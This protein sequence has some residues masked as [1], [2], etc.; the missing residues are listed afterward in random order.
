M[1]GLATGDK[2]SFETLYRHRY[3]PVF[4]FIK[5]FVVDQQA[6][7]DITTDT[8]LKV[9]KKRKDFA[10]LKK[11]DAFLFTVAR[12][13]SL[14]Y[15]RD[16]KRHGLKNRLLYAAGAPAEQPDLAEQEVAVRVYEYIYEEIG[17]LPE[18]MQTVLRLHLEGVKNAAIAEQLGLAEKTVRNLKA[19]AIKTLRLRLSHTEFALLQLLLLAVHHGIC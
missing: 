10:G 17:K 6:A 9:W 16:E 1:A 2:H 19:E 13:S 3:L 12:R 14:N 4:H 5:R 11:L 7:E 15:L 18:K 8:F